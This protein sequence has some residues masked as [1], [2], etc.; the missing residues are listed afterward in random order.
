M[1]PYDSW[2]ELNWTELNVVYNKGKA[3][4]GKK[5]EM[6]AQGWNH[7]EGMRQRLNNTQKRIAAS[8][9][10]WHLRDPP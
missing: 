6:F 4:S 5:L 7:A 1:N 9:T 10:T 3:N 8:K 2:T